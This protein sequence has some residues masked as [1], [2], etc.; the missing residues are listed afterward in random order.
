MIIFVR[1]SLL[2][3]MALARNHRDIS[4]LRVIKPAASYY[5]RHGSDDDRMKMYLYL[6][7]AQYDAGDPESAIASYTRAEEYS[8]RSDNLVFKGIISSSISDVY[9]WNHNNSESISYCKEACDYFAQARDSF[10]LWSQC[11]MTI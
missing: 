6:G 10:R 8:F 1:Y 4:D 2:Y 5:D 7:A 9:L 11:W 3:T